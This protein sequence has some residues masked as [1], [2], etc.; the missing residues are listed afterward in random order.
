ME[1]LKINHPNAYTYGLNLNH[2]L[3]SSIK[4]FKYLDTELLGQGDD[5][6][7]STPGKVMQFLQKIASLGDCAPV[8]DT[9]CGYIAKIIG[10]YVEQEK[11]LIISKIASS[12]K[13]LQP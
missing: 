13:Y 1:N 2:L 3:T 11:K 12:V 6:V 10:F 5:I 9:A 8:I 4:A 7:K